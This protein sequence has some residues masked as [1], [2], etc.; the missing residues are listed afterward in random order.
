[1]C[2][3]CLIPSLLMSCIYDGRLMNLIRPKYL[4]SNLANQQRMI[5][6]L[7][8][9]ETN[10]QLQL[11]TRLPENMVNKG[12]KHLIQQRKNI[13]MLELEEAKQ[14]IAIVLQKE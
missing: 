5:L 3:K 10:T 12:L 1:M 9:R 14:Q 6:K 13:F 2:K 11:P 7:Y 8:R 4:P